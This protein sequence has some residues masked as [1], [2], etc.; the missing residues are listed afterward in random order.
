MPHQLRSMRWRIASAYVLLIAGTL[1]L[2]GA[3]VSAHFSGRFMQR[4]GRRLG[5]GLG[6]VVGAGGMLLSG[7]GVLFSSFALFL[8]GVTVVGAARGAADQSRYAAADTQPP[9]R[10]GWAI[11][12]IVFA[13]TVGAAA[14][15][16]LASSRG[17]L[18]GGLTSV[19]QSGTMWAGALLFALAGV[20]VFTLLRPDPQ[21]L[22]RAFDEPPEAGQPLV[23]GRSLGAVLRLPA[24]QLALA[25]IV[26][27]QA[28]MVLVMSV[29]SLHMDHSHHGGDA[30]SLVFMAHTIGMF[31]LSIVTGRVIDRIGRRSAILSGVALLVS[32]SLIAPVSLQTQWLALALFLVG[33]GWNLCYV[34]GSTLLSDILAPGER[35]G[36]QGSIELIVNVISASCNLLSGVIFGA[37]GYTTL[38]LLGAALALVPLLVLGAQRLRIPRPAA[39]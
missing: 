25:A 9:E 10:R 4:Y 34:G 15:P 6:F 20:L 32:G 16:W 31:G 30:I 24:A 23:A 22:G 27:G 28:T 38:G 2:L 3:A 8:L 14:G 37:F 29:T 36:I 1:L 5:L 35:G 18:L 17:N 12:M 7:A 26:I 33:L 21:E 13:S 11:S 19:P 39:A